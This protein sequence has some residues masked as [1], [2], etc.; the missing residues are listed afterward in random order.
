[1]NRKLKG[2][3]KGNYR[4]EPKGDE[5]PMELSRRAGEFRRVTDGKQRERKETS[6]KSL[7]TIL[8]LETLCQEIR[9]EAK[10][11][12]HDGTGSLHQGVE[13]QQKEIERD[14]ERD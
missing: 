10:E 13:G 11:A 12:N 3:T 7:Q 2:V 5:P 4:K 14:R 8:E 1:M 9:R 6:L